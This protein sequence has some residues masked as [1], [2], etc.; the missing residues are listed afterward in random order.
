MLRENAA[1]A[2]MFGSVTKWISMIS[3]LK[4]KRAVIAR[5]ASASDSP[6][7]DIR[8]VWSFK[9]IYFLFRVIQHVKRYLLWTTKI[10]IN[11][12]LFCYS[13][14]V[15]LFGYFLTDLEMLI[16]PEGACECPLAKTKKF[17]SK[18]IVLERMRKS[19]GK[20]NKNLQLWAHSRDTCK[21]NTIYALICFVVCLVRFV[22]AFSYW[23]RFA[24][25]IE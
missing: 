20:E 15:L 18:S 13:C 24:F 10:S 7:I 5:R 21:R 4:T 6:A 2:T 14:F 19:R 9:L 17:G 3:H 1:R 23:Q 16:R 12:C 11:I 8:N 25:L 22:F